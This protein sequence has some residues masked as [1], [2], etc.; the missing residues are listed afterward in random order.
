MGGIHEAYFLFVYLNHVQ[1]GGQIIDGPPVDARLILDSAYKWND[2]REERT[3]GR[4][5]RKGETRIG[6]A[7]R[8]MREKD[9]ARPGVQTGRH[10]LVVIALLQLCKQA[11]LWYGGTAFKTRQALPLGVSLVATGK[12]EERRKEMERDPDADFKSI[13]L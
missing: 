12:E 11:R 13:G 8:R 2:S 3:R 7:G 10:R 6:S 5:G 1:R 4:K 9:N